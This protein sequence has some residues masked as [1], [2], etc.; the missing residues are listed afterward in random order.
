MLRAAVEH[1]RRQQRLVALAVAAGRRAWRLVDRDNL[2]ALGPFL[3]ALLP[4]LT[5]AQRTSAQA[6]AAYVGRA[7]AEQGIG[8][9]PVGQVEPDAFAGTAA[10]GRPLA[11][12][13]IEPV[14]RVKQD[15]GAGVSVA[16]AMDAG[17]AR[18]DRI[19]RTET[20]DAGRVAAGVGIA[21]TPRVGY[22]RMVNP[23]CCGRCAILAGRWYRWNAGFQRHPNCDCVHIPSVEDA[24]GDLRTDPKAL[25]AAGEVT[26]LSVADAEAVADGAD[27]ARVV[28]AHRGMYAA[29]GRKFT[30]EAA[31]RRRPRLMPEQIYRDAGS[32]ADAVRLLRL[33]GYIT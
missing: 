21:A 13:L 29:G 5:G 8:V 31:G 3:A 28:N 10:D 7:L 19:T 30:H 23:P 14:I 1:Y 17:R 4:V 26:G 9:D 32:R 22:V 33:H 12:L 25:F 16:A 18:L 20:A 2:D 15:I 27:L 24:A 11:T 6:G